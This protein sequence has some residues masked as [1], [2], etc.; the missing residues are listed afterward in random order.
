VYNRAVS[1]PWVQVRIVS[2][3]IA[4]V[5]ASDLIPHDRLYADDGVT[6]TVADLPRYLPGPVLVHWSIEPPLSPNRFRLAGDP[7]EASG[8]RWLDAEQIVLT[9]ADRSPDAW[10]LRSVEVRWH[11]HHSF[12]L[13]LSTLTFALVSWLPDSVRPRPPAGRAASAV[14]MLPSLALLLFQGVF[15]PVWQQAY[16]DWPGQHMMVATNLVDQGV[17]GW[18]IDQME[19]YGQQVGPDWA[20]KDRQQVAPTAWTY[21]A[22]TLLVAGVIA[23]ERSV[24][25]TWPHDRLGIFWVNFA[26]IA[27]GVAATGAAIITL[28]LT[29]VAASLVLVG[30]TRAGWPAANA[31]HINAEPLLFLINAAALLAWSTTLHVAPPARQSSALVIL[32]ALAGVGQLTKPVIGVF[33]PLTFAVHILWRRRGNA[34]CPRLA[35]LSFVVLAALPTLAWTVRNVVTIGAPVVTSAG[36]SFFLV[37][38]LHPRLE[39]PSTIGRNE[40]E[41]EALTREK[42]LPELVRLARD[43]EARAAYLEGRLYAYFPGIV[44]SP[45]FRN[46]RWMTP[47]ASDVAP[48]FIVAVVACA[49]VCVAVGRRAVMRH[50]A[51][52]LIVSTSIVGW[53][54]FHLIVHPLVRYYPPITPLYVALFTAVLL[55]WR[56]RPANRGS[57]R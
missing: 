36:S 2:L 50:G 37:Q 3:A 19:R 23:V 54:G 57:A 4:L 42:I 15:A 35:F 16:M 44:G 21:P 6:L 22:Y 31:F 12:W 56:G 46:P 38:G 17:Y 34:G 18:S 9:M 14:A 29:P 47:W 53:W 30:L 8:T 5:F 51:A 39:A 28:G 43:P 25:I 11:D 26:L 55:G 33:V 27:L 49:I 20:V 45:Q 10:S 1:D 41:N 48:A 32:G 7:I 13:V 40:L 52:P 24:G